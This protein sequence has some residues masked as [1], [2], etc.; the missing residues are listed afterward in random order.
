[1]PTAVSNSPRRLI[2]ESLVVLTTIVLLIVGGVMTFRDF[3]QL[4]ANR[5]RVRQ[6]NAVLLTLEATESAMKDAETGQRGFIITGREPYLE[7]FDVAMM[8]VNQLVDELEQ[9]TA[10]SPDQQRRLPGLRRL[11]DERMAELQ[12][13][14]DQRRSGGLEAG[15]AAV[16]TDIGKRT[17]D[18]IRQLIEQ[19]RQSEKE[20]LVHRKAIAAASDRNGKITATLL[21]VVGLLLVGGVIHLNHRNRVRAE[22]AAIY[23]HGILDGLSEMVIVLDDGL[24]IR[25]LNASTRSTFRVDESAPLDQ[26]IFELASGSLDMPA[27]RGLIAQVHLGEVRSSQAVLQHDFASIGYRVLRIT[28]HRFEP[29]LSYRGFSPAGDLRHDRGTRDRGQTSAV[30]S[31]H[32]VVSRTTARLCNFHHGRRLPGD[33]LEPGCPAGARLPGRTIYRPRRSRHDFHPRIDRR[34]FGR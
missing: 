13:A 30:G 7:P 16:D 31:A 15:K 19:M 12:I 6:T 8:R 27:V 24:K 23:T 14:I 28:A 25:T 11:I 29:T 17:M 33:E 18:S 2:A 9:M 21:T 10:D 5:G 3:R 1:M 22:K 34:R 26:S 20:R 32:A 4:E